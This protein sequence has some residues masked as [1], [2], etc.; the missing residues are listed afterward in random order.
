MTRT[1]LYILCL[2]IISAC[3]GNN[4][5]NGAPTG[6]ERDS[7]EKTITSDKQPGVRFAMQDSIGLSTTAADEGI[8]IQN[9][10]VKLL[11]PN[12]TIR[13]EGQMKDGKRHGIW[14][15]YY[16]DGTK[17][18]VNNYVLGELNGVSLSY[19]PNESVRFVGEY[20][21]GKRSGTWKF[22]S[23]TGQIT[24]KQF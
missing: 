18:S 12:G 13:V 9:G 7:S 1:S 14:T 15:S 4:E 10:P 3:S 22:Y 17:W 2:A 6:M 16:K 24:E 11:Y 20:T 5:Q 21:H 19:Y 23:N 8:D